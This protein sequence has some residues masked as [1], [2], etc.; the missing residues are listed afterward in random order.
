MRSAS[1][2]ITHISYWNILLENVVKS[3]HGYSFEQYANGEYFVY[4]F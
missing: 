3:D 4:F 1:M 2:S